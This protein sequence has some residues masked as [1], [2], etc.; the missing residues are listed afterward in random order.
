MKD[1]GDLELFKEK[2][3]INGRMDKY[4]KETT[5]K[6]WEMEWVNIHF[7]MVVIMKALGKMDFKKEKELLEKDTI[8]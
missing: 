2:V 6:V 4:T 1:N 8:R 5:K 3:S 7:Q